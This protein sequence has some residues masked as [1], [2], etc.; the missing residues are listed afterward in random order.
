MKRLN[1]IDGLKGWC[2]A[3]VC[4]LHFLLMFEIGGF[5]GWK[6]MPEAALNPFGYYFEWFPYSVLTNNSFPLYIFFALISFIVSYTLTYGRHHRQQ[7][8][9]HKQSQGRIARSRWLHF[10]IVSARFAARLYKCGHALCTWRRI[11]Y[12]WYPLLFW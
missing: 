2:A 5:I 9:F 3:S 4:I 8:V 10:G 12:R 6:C 11:D 1:Y 7:R